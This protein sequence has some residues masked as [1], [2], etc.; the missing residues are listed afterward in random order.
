[1]RDHPQ[2]QTG[3]TLVELVMVIVV[4]GVL[5]G[6][7]ANF[8]VKPVRGYLD[9][10]RRAELTDVADTALIRMTREIRLGLPN[11]IRIATGGNGI[12]FL[13]TVSGVRYRAQGPGD[14]LDFSLATDSFDALGGITNP[15]TIVTDAAATVASCISGSVYCLAVFNTGQTGADAYAGD[16]IAAL[17]SAS[18]TTIEFSRDSPF[19]FTSPAQRA[20]VVDGPVS[21]LCE[22]TPDGT[23][24]RYSAYPI[25][26]NHATVDTSAELTAAGAN[27]HLLADNVESCDF[28]YVAGS[29]SRAG[30]VR[31][32]VDIARDGEQVALLQQ[33]HV[34]NVP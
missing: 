26:T 8:I 13:R 10:S 11:S 30:L 9:L 24:V 25:T 14:T 19:P 27:A 29:S 2:R 7:I 23:I 3:F 16:T 6:A 5:A 20:Y 21:Y 1:M 32:A 34:S 4:T 18:A 12:E 28:S 17:R 31:V 33:I 15:G 22:G